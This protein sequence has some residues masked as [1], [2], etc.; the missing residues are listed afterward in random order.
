MLYHVT[1]N[2]SKVQQNFANIQEEEI[3]QITE[4]IHWHDL[5]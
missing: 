3:D 5:I 1:R 2:L 4:L